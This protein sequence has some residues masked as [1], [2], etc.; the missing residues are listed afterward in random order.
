[1]SLAI[2]KQTLKFASKAITSFP[3]FSKIIMSFSAKQN[4]MK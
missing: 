4:R 3:F 2:K 1:M